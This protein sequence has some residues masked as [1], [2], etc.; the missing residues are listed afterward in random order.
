MLLCNVGIS[1][2]RNPNQDWDAGASQVAGYFSFDRS[3]CALGAQV[4]FS[5]GSPVIAGGC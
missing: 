1:E 3:Q 5:L 4:V 2:L